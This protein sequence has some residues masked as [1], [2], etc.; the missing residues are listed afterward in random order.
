MKYKSIKA[1]PIIPVIFILVMGLIL[2]SCATHSQDA[3][4]WGRA[5]GS[6]DAKGSSHHFIL[7]SLPNPYTIDAH[8][9]CGGKVDGV[10]SYSSTGD[11]FLAAFG[12]G[13]LLWA[14]RTYKIYCN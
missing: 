11:K 4:I 2:S 7:T 13:G 10:E 5:G 1:V 9:I 12:L 8:K 3:R 14:P 6:Y